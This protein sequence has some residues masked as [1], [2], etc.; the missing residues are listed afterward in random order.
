MRYFSLN[1]KFRPEVREWLI[2]HVGPKKFHIHG[3]WEGGEKW[4]IGD[5]SRN[6][7]AKNHFYV[8]TDEKIATYLILRFSL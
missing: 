2:T 1:A 7:P 8:A 4:S 3:D 5:R 6:A